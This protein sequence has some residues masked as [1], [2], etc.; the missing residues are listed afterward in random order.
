M[1]SMISLSCVRELGRHNVLLSPLRF[2]DV[3]LSHPNFCR[4][5]GGNKLRLLYTLALSWF[6]GCKGNLKGKSQW[7]KNLTLS[8]QT[9]YESISV[10]QLLEFWFA[11]DRPSY[12]GLQCAAES[13]HSS[14]RRV[15]PQRL[16][17]VKRGTE[18]FGHS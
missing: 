6:S 11:C 18:F 10:N 16:Y 1:I 5:P 9:Q 15:P 17:P 7:K 14:D 3:V 8:F 4:C 12:F 13:T 2:P